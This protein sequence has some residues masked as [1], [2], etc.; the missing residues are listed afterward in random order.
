[1][2]F[3]IRSTLLSHKA[4]RHQ[5]QLALRTCIQLPLGKVRELYLTSPTTARDMFLR[6]NRGMA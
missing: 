2:V 3:L 5:Q 6:T 4:L 1:M